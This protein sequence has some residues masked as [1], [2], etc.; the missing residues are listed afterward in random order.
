MWKMDK[1]KP[2]I[3]EFIFEMKWT[4]GRVSNPDEN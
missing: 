3:G 4:C 1:V 2:E